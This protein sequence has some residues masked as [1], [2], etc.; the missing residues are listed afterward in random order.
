MGRFLNADVFASTGQGILGN[1]MFAYCLNNPVNRI[2]ISGTVSL[3]YYLIVDSD[4]GFIHRMVQLHILQKYE[5]PYTKELTLG[6]FGRA[7]IVDTSTGAVW[8]VK[9]ASTC[10]NERAAIA[11]SQAKGYVGGRHENIKITKLGKAQTFEGSFYILCGD[12]LYLINYE[13]PL[14]GAILYSVREVRNN[15]RRPFAEYVP[16]K[17]FSSSTAQATAALIVAGL[18]ISACGGGSR[19]PAKKYDPNP[20]MS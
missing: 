13:T 14:D 12:S 8:E 11:Q 10:P 15:R 4:Y 19:Q 7:D 20:S 1:N 5:H 18:V 6:G 17:E 2:D 16:K 9:H 3:W